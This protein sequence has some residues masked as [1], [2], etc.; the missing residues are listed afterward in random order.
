MLNTSIRSPAPT[1]L[2][3]LNETSFGNLNDLN[4]R[5]F[6]KLDDTNVNLALGDSLEKRLNG[7]LSTVSRIDK[8]NLSHIEQPFDSPEV[9]NKRLSQ[10]VARL[11]KTQT[12]KFSGHFSPNKTVSPNKTFNSSKSI[13]LSFTGKKYR[14]PAYTA[15]K[16]AAKIEKKTA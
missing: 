12:Q 7:K 15:E 6:G 5:S 2:Q 9:Y 10:T 16:R 14:N 11:R 1:P 3:Y 4:D 8:L 13:E